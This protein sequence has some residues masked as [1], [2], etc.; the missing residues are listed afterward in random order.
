M[1]DAL[2]PTSPIVPP[3]GLEP[4]GDPPPWDWLWALS[5]LSPSGLPP[6][7][8]GEPV[9]SDP[10]PCVSAIVASCCDHVLLSPPQVTHL[11][12]PQF[13]RLGTRLRQRSDSSSRCP[14]FRG[15]K[16]NLGPLRSPRRRGGRERQD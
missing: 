16:P 15:M 1:S 7:L 14:S 12:L 3:D 11:E 10:M 13:V 5:E 8:A 9:G 4:P 2:R 6:G